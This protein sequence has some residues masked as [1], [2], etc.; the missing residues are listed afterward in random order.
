MANIFLSNCGQHAS[1][2]IRLLC[3]VLRKFITA[4]EVAIRLNQQLIK[5]EQLELQEALEE[6]MG[7]MKEE[8]QQLFAKVERHNNL[9]AGSLSGSLG[10]IKSV[11]SRNTAVKNI[12]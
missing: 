9:K 1:K 12:N 3:T 8:L 6:R 4:S 2:H 11:N 10:S 7:K 5:S